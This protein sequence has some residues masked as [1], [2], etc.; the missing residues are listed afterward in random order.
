MHLTGGLPFSLIKEG[1]LNTYP[2]LTE[3]KEVHTVIIGGGISGALSAYYLTNAG[4]NCMLVDGRTIGLGSTCASTSL[5]QYE[6]DVP[7]HIL[8][9][10]VGESAAI[11]A[12]KLCGNSI[13]MIVQ[14]MNDI[15]FS[16][17]QITPSLYFS[18]H[19]HEK[20]FMQKEFAARK[21][22]GFDVSFLNEDELKKEYGLRRMYAIL[23]Q[24]GCAAM[25][26]H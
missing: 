13:D 9:K 2:K 16:D 21:S 19:R 5:L 18:M 10:K 15:N 26:T 24:Q 8:K 7:L 4:I 23:S 17:Y 25:P 22:A 11:T 20:K 14:I 3:N 1:L 12:Y 6:L